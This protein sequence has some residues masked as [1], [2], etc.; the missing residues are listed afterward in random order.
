LPP[1]P[2]LRVETA[3]VLVPS[4]LSTENDV[5]HMRISY[6]VTRGPVALRGK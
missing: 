2:K 3:V 6:A 4:D 5:F 1:S